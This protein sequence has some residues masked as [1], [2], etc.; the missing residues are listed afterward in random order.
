MAKRTSLCLDAFMSNAQND[1]DFIE[2]LINAMPLP[3]YF[4]DTDLKYRGCNEAFEKI[5]GYKKNELIGN[6]DRKI[7]KFEMARELE[8]RDKKLLEYPGEQVFEYRLEPRCGFDREVVFHKTLLE[9]QQGKPTGIV[10]VVKDVTEQKQSSQRLEEINRCFLNFTPEPRENIESLVRVAGELLNAS[11]ALYVKQ[12][13]DDVRMDATWNLSEQLGFNCPQLIKI[14]KRLLS[15]SETQKVKINFLEDNHCPACGSDCSGFVTSVSQLIKTDHFAGVLFVLHNRTF[16]LSPAERKLLGVIASAIEVEENRRQSEE[17]LRRV[18]SL[19]RALEE[20][21]KRFRQMTERVD[22]VFL[23]FRGVFD[24]ILYANSK[25]AEVFDR[26]SE[27]LRDDP[28]DFLNRISPDHRGGLERS[29]KITR[30][31]VPAS[32]VVETTDNPEKKWL[33]FRF[34]PAVGEDGDISS[35]VVLVQDVTDREEARRQLAAAH[36]ELKEKTGQIVQNEKMTA[37]GELTASVAHELNQPLNVIKIIAQSLLRNIGQINADEE[38]KEDLQDIVGQVNKMAEIIDHMRVFSRKSAGEKKDNVDLNELF[39]GVFKFVGQQ[40]ENHRI[41]VKKDLAGDLANVAG[42]P[43]RIE[44]IFMNLITNAR[45]VL[46][47]VDQQEKT[48][49][50]RTYNLEQNKSPLH[51]N[52]VVAEVEDNGPGVPE[53]I[54]DK[55]FEPFFTTREPGKGTGLGLSVASEVIE[56]HDGKMELETEKGEYALFRVIL[57]AQSRAAVD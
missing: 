35:V 54:R 55:I 39:E 23:L 49:I 7:F 4:K 6:Q 5:T 32:I 10:G 51:V 43:I 11:A 13:D 14:S 20:S 34:S 21:E 9:D 42:D 27:K 46:D 40:L 48:I 22:G 31:G 52:S 29:I 36:E 3:V 8:H 57:P 53:D 15:Q 25:Y 28:E 1:G 50:V 45:N 37:L 47:D 2:Q 24:E 16:E 12:V 56:E 26:S 18:E 33:D 17:E 30:Q 41:E 38:L 19:R 44:Q